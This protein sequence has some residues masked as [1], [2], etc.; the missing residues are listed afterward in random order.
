MIFGG[1]GLVALIIV[2]VVFLMQEDEKP[3]QAE[4]AQTN[5][6]ST[7]N[8]GDAD[9]PDQKPAAG[10][11]TNDGDKPADG[12]EPIS[13]DDGNKAIGDNPDAKP[14]EAS[15]P[16]QELPPD[17]PQWMKIKIQ[18]MDQ[19]NTTFAEVP[20]DLLSADKKAEVQELAANYAAGGRPGIDAEKAMRERPYEAMFG[21]LDIL[22]GLDHTDAFEMSSAYPLNRFMTE[23]T[24]G[25]QT[26]FQAVTMDEQIDPRKAEW[27]CRSTRAWL[28]FFKTHP[29]TATFEELNEERRKKELKDG[30]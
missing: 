9:K 11:T 14:A 16:Q 8:G 21:L 5:Q 24:H 18:T 20:W 27:N 22:R 10:D 28:T 26:G 1:I 3:D 7:G 12:D 17:A 30:K 6:E 13:V 25:L 4:D 23:I 29:D 15:A 2:L 19:V